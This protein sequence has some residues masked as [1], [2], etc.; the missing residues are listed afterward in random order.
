MGHWPVLSQGSDAKGEK[1]SSTNL[2][3]VSNNH[4]I[5]YRYCKGY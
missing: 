3:K 1:M 4:S 2:T 5:F